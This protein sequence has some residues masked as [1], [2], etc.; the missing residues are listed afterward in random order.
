MLLPVLPV[1]FR[2]FVSRLRHRSH[3]GSGPAAHACSACRKG[4]ISEIVN[5]S[6]VREEGRQTMD[7]VDPPLQRSDMRDRLL[8]QG[9]HSN[10]GALISL[11]GSLEVKLRW[12]PPSSRRRSDWSLLRTGRPLPPH[13]ESDHRGRERR[14]AHRPHT[15]HTQPSAPCVH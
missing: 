4:G 11:I 5:R 9:A 13:R 12:D 1:P 8:S 2:R 6:A 15:A 3:V 14:T 10:Q 7:K